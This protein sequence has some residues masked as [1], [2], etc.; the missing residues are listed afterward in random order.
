MFRLGG[1]QCLDGTTQLS[2]YAG[3]DILEGP[4]QLAQIKN[5]RIRSIPSLLFFL[6]L[7][8]CAVLATLVEFG[9]AL[10]QVTAVCNG[11]FGA[12]DGCSFEVEDAERSEGCLR[13]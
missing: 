9:D 12:E 1:T 5:A 2:I 13:T 7:A 6:R 11:D 3:G 4:P 10:E 8:W